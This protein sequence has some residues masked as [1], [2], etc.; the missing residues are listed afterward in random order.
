[1]TDFSFSVHQSIHAFTPDEWN[2]CAGYRNPFVSYE[3]LSALEE[4]GST[5]AQTGWLPLH[6]ALRNTHGE[7]VGVA[8][9]YAK[10]HSYGEYVFDHS[11]AHAYE[12]HGH[13]Y[14][15]KLQ[16]AV[17][18]SPVPGPRLLCAGAPE[19]L[20]P[21]I[22]SL[23]AE[24]IS[25]FCHQNNLSSAHIT[26][27][28]HSEYKLLGGQG[29]LQRLGMQYHWYN[30]GYQDFDDF[31]G[32]LSSRK[33]KAIRKERADIHASGLQFKIYLGSEITLSLWQ[34][35]YNFYLSTVEQKWGHA[36][37]TA[38]FFPLLSQK[39][40]DRVVLMIAEDQEKAVA[41]ALNLLGQYTLYGRNWGSVGHWPFLH[42]ELCYYQAIEF[43]IRHNL[44]RVEAGA[45]GEHKIQRGY[46]PSPTYSLHWIE[47]PSFKQAIDHFLKKERMAIHT[48]MQ[49]LHQLSPFKHSS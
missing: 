15:P 12:E 10:T 25:Q 47:D 46:E 6:A 19:A 38:E 1:M 36:Y 2:R 31:L 42:F 32:A 37:L 40:G 29:W 11:W 45:Q 33:R 30:K 24:R 7:L 35:F 5:S 3:F 34:A 41:G 4:S 43:A 16:S 23:L 44:R 18:F 21:T 20:R 39:M 17:P 26:F 49:S 9:L 8:P 14:Y 28:S 22:Q 48:E 27:C 13:A